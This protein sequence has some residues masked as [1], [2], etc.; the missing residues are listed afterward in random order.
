ML[1]GCLNSCLHV[2]I[3]HNPKLTYG[4]RKKESG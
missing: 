2:G 3:D 1:D 4:N